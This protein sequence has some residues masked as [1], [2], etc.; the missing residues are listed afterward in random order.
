[1]GRSC[2]AVPTAGVAG[3]GLLENIL[4]SGCRNSDTELT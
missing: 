2:R 1:M 4:V 3:R